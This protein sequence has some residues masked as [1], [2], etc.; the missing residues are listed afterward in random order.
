MLNPIEEMFGTL[1][2]GLRVKEIKN[3]TELNNELKI[4]HEKINSNEFGFNIY[5]NPANDEV[6]IEIN[7]ISFGKIIITNSLGQLFY[8]TE[9]IDTKIKIN[10]SSFPTGIYFVRINNFHLCG[11]WFRAGSNAIFSN[12]W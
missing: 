11:S 12:R 9:F 4:L 8:S 10:L 5:P 6:T 2:H 1:K 3:Y 7:N